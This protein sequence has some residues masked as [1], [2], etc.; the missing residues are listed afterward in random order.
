LM[1][2]LL[3]HYFL[4]FVEKHCG[5]LLLLDDRRTRSHRKAIQARRTDGE[6]R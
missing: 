5:D 1:I 3:F 6:R 4:F 2:P